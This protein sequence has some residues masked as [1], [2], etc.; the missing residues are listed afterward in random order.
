VEDKMKKSMVFMFVA[1]WVLFSS[2]AGADQ[3]TMSVKELSSQYFLQ[4]L[5]KNMMVDQASCE[6]RPDSKPCIDFACSK[7]YCGDQDRA[8]KVA[9][10]CANNYGDD[11]VKLACSKVYCG[12]ETRLLKVINTCKYNYDNSCTNFACSKVY[13]GDEDRLLRVISSCQGTDTG[14]VE[15]L[16][17]R[18][19][20][21]D[22][23]RLLEVINSCSGR[24]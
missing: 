16:C 18:V 4:N 19:Y 11:C 22:E 2:L 10:A 7:V 21:G 23:S 24:D 20:C 12:D 13:C 15:S 9:R 14:C 8:F 6:E 1:M 17:S 5:Q 3:K